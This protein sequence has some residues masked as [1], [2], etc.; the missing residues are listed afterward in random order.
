MTCTLG[1]RMPPVNFSW[2]KN[3]FVK[4]LRP[5]LV[6]SKLEYAPTLIR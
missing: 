6:K 3:D 2:V 1:A 5:N 4:G